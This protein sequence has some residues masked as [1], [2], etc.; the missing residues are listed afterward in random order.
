LQW[1]VK[2]QYVFRIKTKSSCA[3]VPL[4]FFIKIK[5]SLLSSLTNVLKLI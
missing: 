3:C 1:L 4:I 5:N 2:A